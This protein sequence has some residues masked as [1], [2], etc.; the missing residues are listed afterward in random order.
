ME[1]TIIEK[2]VNKV[3]ERTEVKFEIDYDGEST[4]D[5]ITVKNK[6]VALLD[7]QKNLIVVDTIKPRYGE[8][9]AVG[10][11]KVYET[12]EALKDIETKSVIEKNTEPEPEPAEEEAEE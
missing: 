3:L 2:N 6:L 5:T 11:A 1:Y 8:P 10:Y 4:P 12:E 9:V 7:T